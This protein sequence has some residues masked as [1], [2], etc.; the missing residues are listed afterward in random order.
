MVRME[1]IRQLKKLESVQAM[2]SMMTKA[3]TEVELLRIPDCN[4]CTTPTPSY[5]DGKTTT[6][7]WAYMCEW[8]FHLMGIG[9]GLGR[10]QKLILKGED[11]E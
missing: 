6:G 8:H 11:N 9:L 4:Y 3:D 7:P 10:G 2:V 5:V 1:V